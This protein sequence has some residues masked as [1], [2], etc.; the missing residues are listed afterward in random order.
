M[1]RYL[2]TM[3]RVRDLDKSVAF[4]SNLLGMTELRRREVARRE[5]HPLLPGL[6]KQPGAGRDRA[7]L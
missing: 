6:R 7:D 2:H 4:Y 5:I 3:L 1:S